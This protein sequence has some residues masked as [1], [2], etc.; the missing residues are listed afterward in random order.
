MLP[1]TAPIHSVATA[2]RA[3]AQ[4]IIGPIPCVRDFPS[5]DFPVWAQGEAIQATSDLL[6]ATA[7][8]T[9]AVLALELCKGPLTQIPCTLWSECSWTTAQWR[10]ASTHCRSVL[11]APYINPLF[12]PDAR[13]GE[14]AGA[15]RM[16][17][18]YQAGRV[19][20]ASACVSE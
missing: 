10:S 18:K 15:I 7:L 20:E 4:I 6:K 11:L 1:T 8:S 5:R 12:F 13:E 17:S 3:S 16:T 9:K 19:E 2:K 14:R